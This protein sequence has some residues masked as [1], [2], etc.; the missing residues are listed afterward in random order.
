MDP[1]PLK[2]A[3]Q[4]QSPR[5]GLPADVDRLLEQLR[6]DQRRFAATIFWRDVREVGTCAVMVPV[7]IVMGLR[8]NL[9]WTWYLAVPAF[10]WIA[11][12]M[13]VDRWRHDPQPPDPGEPLRR[14]VERS[15]AQVEHQI[16][17][18]R[19][20]FWWYLLPMALAILAF[21]VQVSWR[22]LSGGGWM[23]LVGLIPVAV[24]GLVFAGIYR[25]NQYAVRGA[26]EPQRLE[27]AAMLRGLEGGPSDADGV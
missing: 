5:A 15:L 12:F 25:L 14:H 26:L 16:V 22:E 2:D 9:P 27:L 6:S 20:V 18:L 13:L 8:Q 17:L 4:A 3:W 10:L 23:A 24:V 1:D 11:G 19:N 21:F 7:W